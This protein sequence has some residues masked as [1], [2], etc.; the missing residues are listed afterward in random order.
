MW[1]GKLLLGPVITFGRWGWLWSLEM[2]SKLGATDG[3]LDARAPPDRRRELGWLESQVPPRGKKVGLVA[4]AHAVLPEYPHPF[5]QTLERL[6]S[7]GQ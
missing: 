5:R 7:T 1:A 2:W 4:R 3:P 6:D